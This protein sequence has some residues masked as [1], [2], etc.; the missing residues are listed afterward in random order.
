MQIDISSVIIGLASLATFAVPIG[1]DQYKVKRAKSRAKKQFLDT[2]ANVGFQY[3]SYDILGN[4]AVIGIGK[5]SEELLYV[6]NDTDHR[7]IELRNLTSCRSYETQ[8]KIV[9]DDG[10]HR[11]MKEVG[12]RLTVSENGKIKL[13]VF[14]GRDG[15]QRGNESIVVEKWISR[16][17][18]AQKSLHQGIS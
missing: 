18:S 15:T 9:A 1:Y 2:S 14:E 17:A 11:N 5:N 7:L 3:D 8:D 16:I 13:P 12:I 6:K 10:S 4:S